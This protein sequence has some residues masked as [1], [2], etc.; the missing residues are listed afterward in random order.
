MDSASPI[1]SASHIRSNAHAEPRRRIGPSRQCPLRH[2][3]RPL[4]KWSP[5]RRPSPTRQLH[6]NCSSLKPPELRFQFAILR[7]QD[8]AV[9]VPLVSGTSN[10]GLATRS[11]AVWSPR[12]RC[13]RDRL[14]LFARSAVRT[15][16]NTEA[17]FLMFA[18]ALKPGRC[19]AS[20]STPMCATRV[21]SGIERIGGQ[22]EGVLRSH[23]LAADSLLATRRVSRSSRRCGQ[24]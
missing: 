10:A 5:V 15:A 8:G 13:L 18:H 21:L 14:H 2:R 3:P 20:A 12:G 1:L 6:R 4:S 16:A 9:I 24:Q 17:K 11:P 7:E 23:R 19:F 22:F